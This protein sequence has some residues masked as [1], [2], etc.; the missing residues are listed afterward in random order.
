MSSSVMIK[1]IKEAEKEMHEGKGK[2]ISTEDL[3]K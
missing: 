1:R 3:W 2:V